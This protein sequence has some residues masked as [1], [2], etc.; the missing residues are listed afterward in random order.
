M[1]PDLRHEALAASPSRVGPTWKTYSDTEPSGRPSPLPL[2]AQD[3]LMVLSDN[4]DELSGVDTIPMPV[5]VV[6]EGSPAANDFDMAPNP[7]KAPQEEVRPSTSELSNVSA[8]LGARTSNPPFPQPRHRSPSI[9]TV[10]SKRVEVEQAVEEMRTGVEDVQLLPETEVSS[11]EVQDEPL[12]EPG[13]LVVEHERAQA[14]EVDANSSDSKEPSRTAAQPQAFE[15]REFKSFF[16]NQSSLDFVKNLMAKFTT[17]PASKTAEEPLANAPEVQSGEEAHKEAVSQVF[18]TSMD[19]DEPIEGE[20]PSVGHGEPGM[21]AAK[22]ERGETGGMNMEI[23]SVHDSD[24]DSDRMEGPSSRPYGRTKRIASTPATSPTPPRIMSHDKWLEVVQ[25]GGDSDIC[26]SSDLLYP[27][28]PN[29][30][31]PVEDFEKEYPP[32]RR[33][34][35][36][37][38]ADTKIHED[39]HKMEPQLTRMPELHREIFAGYITEA[40]SIDEPQAAEIQVLNDVDDEG[41]PQDFEFAYSN[42]PLY[43]KAIP[44]PELTAGCGCDGP[45]DPHSKTCSCLKLQKLYSYDLDLDGFAYNA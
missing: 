10:E 5:P 1:S 26:L 41:A 37:R 2:A 4:D 23:I 38:T 9:V 39:W 30:V 42:R 45:C 15:P 44:D 18:E 27:T 14:S 28:F 29:E 3:E 33:G 8:I 16:G 24:S 19:V 11:T 40:T 17:T 21:L 32:G 35:A 34:T 31:Y 22:A 6:D 43:A 12:G 7:T 25:N 13:T 20:E 36:I